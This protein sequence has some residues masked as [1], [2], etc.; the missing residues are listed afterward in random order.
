MTES[1]PHPLRPRLLLLLLLLLLRRA[2]G[3]I[4]VQAAGGATNVNAYIPGAGTQTQMVYVQHGQPF[5][6]INQ[7]HTMTKL[8]DQLSINDLGYHTCEYRQGDIGAAVNMYGCWIREVDYNLAM[9]ADSKRYVPRCA[10]RNK[11]GYNHHSGIDLMPSGLASKSYQREVHREAEFGKNLDCPHGDYYNPSPLWFTQSWATFDPD[12]NGCM[13]NRMSCQYTRWGLYWTHQD[14]SDRRHFLDEPYDDT[15]APMRNTLLEVD[16]ARPSDSGLYYFAQI[17][18]SNTVIIDVPPTLNPLIHLG[19]A[20]STPPT[21]ANPFRYRR[22][23]VANDVRQGLFNKWQIMSGPDSYKQAL[24]RASFWQYVASFDGAFSFAE[25]EGFRFAGGYD[26]NTENQDPLYAYQTYAVGVNYLDTITGEGPFEVTY[27][28]PTFVTVTT[29]TGNVVPSTLFY[30]ADQVITITVV[31]PAQFVD[32]YAAMHAIYDAPLS[33]RAGLSSTDSYNITPSSSARWPQNSGNK[34][35]ENDLWRFRVECSVYGTGLDGDPPKITLGPPDANFVQTGQY[36]PT[37]DGTYISCW[38]KQGARVQ[39]FRTVG[40][41]FLH[42][43]NLREYATSALV[44]EAGSTILASWVDFNAICWVRANL[45]PNSWLQPDRRDWWMI[46]PN[47]NIPWGDQ[48]VISQRIRLLPPLPPPVVTAVTRQLLPA[49]EQQPPPPISRPPPIFNVDADNKP[50]LLANPG[51]LTVQECVLS[52]LQP[53][54]FC[55]CA[56]GAAVGANMTSGWKSFATT[57]I[58]GQR[59]A[60]SSACVT[61]LTDCYIGPVPVHWW[62]KTLVGVGTLTIDGMGLGVYTAVRD[63]VT[64]NGAPFTAA[65]FFNYSMAEAR[66]QYSCVTHYNCY[67]SSNASSCCVFNT[68]HAV[69]FA[70]SCKLLLMQNAAYH[71][72]PASYNQYANMTTDGVIDYTSTRLL[73]LFVHSA[74]YLFSDGTMC[75]W[76]A[77]SDAACV[78]IGNGSSV[79][80]RRGYYNYT[81]TPQDVQAATVTYTAMIAYQSYIAFVGDV[82]TVVQRSMA[83]FVAGV[84]S[85]AILDLYMSL[86]RLRIYAGN[87]IQSCFDVALF[88]IL[89]NTAYNLP[90]VQALFMYEATLLTNSSVQAVALVAQF[91]TTNAQLDAMIARAAT[92]DYMVGQLQSTISALSETMLVYLA[93]LRSLIDRQGQIAREAAATQVGVN[94]QVSIQNSLNTNLI[95]LN[96]S[97]STGRSGICI[98]AATYA[99][100]KYVLGSGSLLVV[101]AIPFYQLISRAPTHFFVLCCQFGSMILFANALGTLVAGS[102]T[103]VPVSFYASLQGA[104]CG[105]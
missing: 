35:R 93:V 2:R 85:L 29:G 1:L 48:E 83:E 95:A 49:P 50:T 21:P 69:P 44:Y 63:N 55:T 14:Q 92:I 16:A 94:F 7:Q 56:G 23:T 3:S 64:A 77:Q 57:L 51:G 66:V 67:V 25:N 99:L 15:Y 43:S 102:I 78:P 76:L 45:A 13:R 36:T 72:Y 96:A 26:G 105:N 90:S 31:P 17:M 4:T 38:F 75:I 24:A 88:D 104:L 11:P 52:Y 62:V 27:S 18:I 46:V 70:V 20:N 101:T 100:L 86:A 37:V 103:L 53:A 8:C 39:A 74:P 97:I 33:F 28:D 80:S 42:Y 60:I 82:N 9:A 5:A 12:H 98:R 59:Y 40:R 87:N 61:P 79:N 19:W 89:N 22:V 58:A 54:Y 84:E 34:T 91:T 81:L 32:D 65:L 10:N 30:N 71:N 47:Q 73:G 68:N 6:L 41:D